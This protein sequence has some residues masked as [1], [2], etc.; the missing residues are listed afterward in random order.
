[1]RKGQASFFLLERGQDSVFQH[2]NNKKGSDKGSG[3]SRDTA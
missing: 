1:L 3:I 2:L